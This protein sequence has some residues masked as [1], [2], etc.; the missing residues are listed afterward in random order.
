MHLGVCPSVFLHEMGFELSKYPLESWSVQ[1]LVRL[2]AHGCTV[3]WGA[4][5]AL[6]VLPQPG[7]GLINILYPISK[8]HEYVSDTAE[9]FKGLSAPVWEQLD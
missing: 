8:L 5:P 3:P 7:T 9:H 2:P 4:P 6:Q 1:G